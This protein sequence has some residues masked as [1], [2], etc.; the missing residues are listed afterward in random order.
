MHVQALRASEQEL[1]KGQ[2]EAA[3][4]RE[5]AAQAQEAAEA[6]AAA[7]QEEAARTDAAEHRLRAASKA[8]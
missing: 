8:C 4:L 1:E 2:R 3:A 5:A 6:N 7:A